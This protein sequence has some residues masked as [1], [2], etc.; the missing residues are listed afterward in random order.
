MSDAQR[1]KTFNP[2]PSAKA[3]RDW[4]SESARELEAE[5]MT[6]FRSS[7]NETKDGFTMWVEGWRVQPDDQGSPPWQRQ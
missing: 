1:T 2:P 4:I 6:F 5:G 7:Y 3:Y